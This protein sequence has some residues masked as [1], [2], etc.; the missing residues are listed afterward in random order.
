MGLMKI[1]L[2]QAALCLERGPGV[3]ETENQVTPEGTHLTVSYLC[4]TP[5]LSALPR[6]FK[7]VRLLYSC[8]MKQLDKPTF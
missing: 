3:L 6:N 1:V 8:T 5:H 7:D 2:S 4:V